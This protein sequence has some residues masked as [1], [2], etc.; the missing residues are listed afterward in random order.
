MFL[1]IIEG[2]G[3]IF[4]MITVLPLLVMVSCVFWHRLMSYFGQGTYK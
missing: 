1:T 4:T 3:H 2:L